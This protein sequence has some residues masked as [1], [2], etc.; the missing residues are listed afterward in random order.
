MKL[1]L[2]LLPGLAVLSTGPRVAQAMP[3]F[4]N[5]FQS[6]MVLQRDVPLKLWGFGAGVNPCIDPTDIIVDID[7]GPIKAATVAADGDT[8]SVTFPPQKVP[9]G[10]GYTGINLKCGGNVVQQLEDVAFGDVFLFSGQSNID[11]SASYAHQFNASA[12]AEEEAF[13]DAMGQTGFGI[14][15]MTV[16]NQV[17]GL[18]YNSSSVAR[19]LA[20][21]PDCKPCPAS[22]DASHNFNNCQCNAMRWRPGL[23]ILGYAESVFRPQKRVSSYFLLKRG[24]ADTVPF[25]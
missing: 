10:V 20:S 6:G 15:Y 4:S 21:V 14:R 13:A 7:L 2:L 9:A 25:P 17:N 12:E 16:P 1:L 22:F 3:R 11:I 8:W 23:Q 18:D 5:V 24:G 19:E